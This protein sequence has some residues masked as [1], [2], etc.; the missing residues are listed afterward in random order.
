MFTED[1]EYKGLKFTALSAGSVVSMVKIDGSPNVSVQYSFNG[2][3]WFPFTISSDQIVLSNVDDYVYFSAADNGNQIFMD[4]WASNGDPKTT[5]FMFS[6][7]V[8]ASGNCMSLLDNTVQQDYFTKY[9][10]LGGIFSNTSALVDVSGLLLPCTSL[11]NDSYT[12]MFYKCVSLSS[13]ENLE[14]PA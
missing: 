4:G 7:S 11:Y 2:R 1:G 14:L 13:I 9:S 12:C 10:A 5:H 3:N 6:G 8:R